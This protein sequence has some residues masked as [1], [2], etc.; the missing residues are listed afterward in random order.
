VASIVIAHKDRL[1]R[2][3]F[4]VIN[5]ESLSPQGEMIQD[6]GGNAGEINR[7]FPVPPHVDGNKVTID[8]EKER[9]V[10]KFPK[11]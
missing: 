6:V 4:V 5:N 11:A 2:F 9:L 8:Q 10:L 1:V 7:S 3:G